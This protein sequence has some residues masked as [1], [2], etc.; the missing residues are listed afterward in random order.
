M[1]CPRCKYKDTRVI[2]SRHLPGDDVIR[3][4][5][6]CPNC[7]HRFTTYERCERSSVVMVRKK[8]GRR[9]EFKRDKLLAGL[10]RACD[11]LSVE[12]ERLE[13]AAAAIESQ[14]ADCGE[15]SSMALGRRV[16]E[17]LKKIHKVA[18]VRFAAVY[19]EFKDLQEF[20]EEIR[21]IREDE[22]ERG[23]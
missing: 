18:Y 20:E 19:R 22:R 2:E 5:R 14:L 10:A 7:N 1:K 16:M 6:E 3:R 9:E 4:R 17:E 13:G 21:R 12:R 8:D 11:K 23:L 15:V